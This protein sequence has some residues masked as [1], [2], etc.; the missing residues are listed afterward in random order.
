MARRS[1]SRSLG[2]SLS[3]IEQF[4]GEG[5]FDERRDSDQRVKGKGGTAYTVSANAGML[6]S[7]Q[8]SDS[9]Y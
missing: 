7:A 5:M 6:S 8:P 3:S 2:R 1:Y 9:I 4:W